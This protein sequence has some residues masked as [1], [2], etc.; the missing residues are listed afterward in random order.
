VTPFSRPAIDRAI[1]AVLVSMLRA[2][3]QEYQDN[4]NVIKEAD[5][6]LNESVEIIISRMEEVLKKINP[7]PQT[8]P[9][10]VVLQEELNYAREVMGRFVSIWSAIR[11]KSSSQ[12]DFTY[13]EKYLMKEPDNGKLRLLKPFGK[14]SHDDAF[15]TLTS[16]RN[17]DGAVRGSL[18][19]QL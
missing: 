10:E 19:I 3:S 5:D 14:K 17:V 6:I 8:S 13:G 2:K 1:H 4:P 15:D 18:I 12:D 11:E 16:M 9:S 7:N